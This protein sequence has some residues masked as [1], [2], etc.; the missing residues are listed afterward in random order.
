[1]RNT[2]PDSDLIKIIDHLLPEAQYES[3]KIS[4]PFHHDIS[5]LKP[6]KLRY[7]EI[8]GPNDNYNYRALKTMYPAFAEMAEALDKNDRFDRT[9]FG[10]IFDKEQIPRLKDQGFNDDEIERYRKFGIFLSR[11][12]PFIRPFR[13]G[14]DLKI[15]SKFESDKDL[16][17]CITR[18]RKSFPKAA[19]QFD[20]KGDEHQ[21]IIAI[22]QSTYINRPDRLE[23][24]LAKHGLAIIEEKLSLQKYR[25]LSKQDAALYLKQNKIASSKKSAG[26]IEMAEVDETFEW[27]LP[28]SRPI[29][30]GEYTKVFSLLGKL[31]IYSHID[32][33]KPNIYRITTPAHFTVPVFRFYYLIAK[34]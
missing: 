2:D 33:I 12:E 25:Y 30:I 3:V 7:E 5:P 24:D 17:D 4:L 16:E 8:I 23:I 10:T 21:A 26:I 19:E 13:K 29:T 34:V 27:P 14:Q 20:D 1:M 18:L 15:P 22:Q 9:D 11:M 6:I 31:T 28:I 32:Q